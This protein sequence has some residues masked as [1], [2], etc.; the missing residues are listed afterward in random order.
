MS[1]RTIAVELV[2]GSPKVTGAVLV[3]FVIQPLDASG[4]EVGHAARARIE[5][6]ATRAE[7]IVAAPE[8]WPGEFR[9]DVRRFLADGTVVTSSRP[10]RGPLIVD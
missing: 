5:G 9:V 6:E 10:A 4:A 2:R 1:A 8:D 3:D 7:A